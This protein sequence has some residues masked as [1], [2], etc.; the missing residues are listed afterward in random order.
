[1]L[2][3]IYLGPRQAADSSSLMAPNEATTGKDEYFFNYC[4]D[5][6]FGH[7]L[8]IILSDSR[9]FEY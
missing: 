1:M 2:M 6:V 7:S 9:F 8:N 4:I 5:K 3:R